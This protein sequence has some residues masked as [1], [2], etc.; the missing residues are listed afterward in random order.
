MTEGL[1]VPGFDPDTTSYTD[2]VANSVS[3]IRVVPTAED[4]NVSITVN[5]EPVTSGNMS[6]PKTLAVGSNTISV[7]VT[8]QDTST[9]TY[10]IT[11]IRAASGNANLSNLEVSEGSLNPSF[12]PD[13]LS[14]TDNVGNSVSSIRVTPTT[15]NAAASITVNGDP[16]SS[17]S[18]SSPISLTF[19]S[20]LI[21]VLVT[22]GN[23]L[24]RTY[25]VEVIRAA[26]ANADLSNLYLAEGELDPAFSPDITSYTNLVIKYADSTTATPTAAHEGS[27]ITVNGEPVDSSSESSR[28]ALAVGE[29]T[30]NIVVTAEDGV[31]TKTYT[32]TVI[33]GGFNGG[34]I[35]TVIKSPKN[36][37]YDR[38]NHGSA[39]AKGYLY[40]AGGRS[41]YDGHYYVK[42]DVRYAKIN[43]DG[44]IG[45][46][47]GSSN[48]FNIA[49]KGLTTEAHNGYIYIIGGTGGQ[50]TN[51]GITTVQ[52]A[53]INPNG[54]NDGSIGTF[55]NT[56]SLKVGVSLHSSAVHNGYLYVIG[57]GRYSSSVLYKTVQY[58][59][60]NSDG[61]LGEF[62][63]TTA[64]PAGR[65][66]HT[67]VVQNGYLYV[68]GG[69]G[70][71]SY[72]D[73]IIY[74]K[75]N[76]DGSI[77]AFQ[78]ASNKLY[79][80]MFYHASVAYKGYIYIIGGRIGGTS[81]YYKII[82]FARIS[83]DGDISAFT[84]SSNRMPAGRGYHKAVVSGNFMYITGGYVPGSG[85]TNDVLYTEFED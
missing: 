8:A 2:N 17:G 70:S 49:R 45:A 50:K 39:A 60:I 32:V 37:C 22:S 84:T 80:G 53:K 68:I 16:V 7:V 79:K 11:V 83:S 74:A 15:E 35:G 47:R 29:N 1:L 64:L 13:V 48:S 12:D 65:R 77:G 59:K 26:S 36:F 62:R 73:S 28:I 61:S 42:N 46:F 33:R 18:A 14:Y 41:Y 75:I 67:S 19:G 55:R 10:T 20:N 4:S 21:S 5:G 9:K 66:A 52:Y 78:T 38:I 63:R 71:G 85:Y 82:T 57:G 51:D 81:S 27:T 44:S 76:S 58:A 24:T 40:V 54:R 3:S 31:T 6:D 69:Y 25:T 23:G 34:G 30:V 56:S 72:L 43:S